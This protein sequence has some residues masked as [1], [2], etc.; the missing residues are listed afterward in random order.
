ME[1]VLHQRVTLILARYSI[2]AIYS[3]FVLHF[4]GF[5]R[6]RWSGRFVPTPITALIFIAAGSLYFR[7]RV[8]VLAEPGRIMWG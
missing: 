4:S 7:P 2:V 8:H 5:V 6:Q 3:T 1:C